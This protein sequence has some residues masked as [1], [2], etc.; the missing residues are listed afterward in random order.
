M[1][2][3][4]LNHNG[5]FKCPTGMSVAATALI[6]LPLLIIAMG[7]SHVMWSWFAAMANASTC[8]AICALSKVHAVRAHSRHGVVATLPPLAAAAG[9]V[10]CA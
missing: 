7:I 6:A 10:S 8:L 2:A 9:A 5:T 3:S 4:F 1:D